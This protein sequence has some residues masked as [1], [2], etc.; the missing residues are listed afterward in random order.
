MTA[1]SSSSPAS[2]YTSGL[3][4][5]DCIPYSIVASCEG[6]NTQW[7]VSHRKS[8]SGVIKG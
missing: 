5:R 3:R 2:E 7:R 1:I 6:T 4:E 8:G